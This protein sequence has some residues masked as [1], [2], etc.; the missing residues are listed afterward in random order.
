MILTLVI[1]SN[2]STH[3]QNN[4]CCGWHI[5]N[6]GN[7]ITNRRKSRNNSTSFTP[8]LF[9]KPSLERKGNK[10]RYELRSKTLPARNRK[11]KISKTAVKNAAQTLPNHK[12]HYAGAGGG[13]PPCTEPPTPPPPNGETSRVLFLL[14]LIH[15]TW[16]V[17]TDTKSKRLV[18]GPYRDPIYLQYL[19]WI[20]LLNILIFFLLFSA[21]PTMPKS[22]RNLQIA[23]LFTK[24]KVIIL[25]HSVIY[26]TRVALGLMIPNV[27]HSIPCAVAVHVITVFLWI[28][29]RMILI[30]RM[31]II[32]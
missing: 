24:L 16:N 25:C 19:Q 20:L 11:G 5:S 30:Y 29:R 13:T 3:L 26:M 32:P 12:L 27:V 7:T 6:M 28:P 8:S 15:R 23:I 14:Y 18:K 9:G 1:V 17:I 10:Q 2:A 4:C 22:R 31:F 21:V